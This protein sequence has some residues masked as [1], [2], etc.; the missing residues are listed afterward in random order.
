MV[1]RVGLPALGWL[2][3][4]LVR[5]ARRRRLTAARAKRRNLA[6]GAAPESA[7]VHLVLGRREERLEPPMITPEA[8]VP[9]VEHEGQWH[10]LH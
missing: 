7:R 8:E 9:K 10:T 1:A 4:V 5:T 2:G 6:R 3:F